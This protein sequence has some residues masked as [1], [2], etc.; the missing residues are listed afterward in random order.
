MCCLTT[1]TW[2]GCTTSSSAPLPSCPSTLPLLLCFTGE[3]RSWQRNQKC[4]RFIPFSQ[5]Y[6]WT[7]L[8]RI[9]WSPVKNY[10][11]PYHLHCRGGGK[12]KQGRKREGENE[13]A[14]GSER[15]KGW[16][17]T[18]PFRPNCDIHRASVLGH[19]GLAVVWSVQWCV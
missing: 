19:R 14:K 8:S 17:G 5:E 3:K 12:E 16:K 6:L 13:R 10:M 18:E 11:S 7:C 1:V 4:P 9:F 2:S 15:R